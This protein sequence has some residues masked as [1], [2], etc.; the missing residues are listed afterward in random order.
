MMVDDELF[1]N[2]DPAKIDRILETYT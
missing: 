2:L 1:G